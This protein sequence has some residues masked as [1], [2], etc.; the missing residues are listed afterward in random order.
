[1]I[2]REGD[3]SEIREHAPRDRFVHAAAPRMEALPTANPRWLRSVEII[4]LSVQEALPLRSLHRPR[5][6]RRRRRRRPRSLAAQPARRAPAAATASEAG[7][8]APVVRSEAAAA[9]FA[10][11]VGAELRSQRDPPP[12]R[13]LSRLRHLL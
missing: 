4:P 5:S 9:W 13:S 8:G 2:P 1:M 11:G 3:D 12:R 6:R 10:V 7:G